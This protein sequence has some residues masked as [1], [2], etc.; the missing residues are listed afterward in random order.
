MWPDDESDTEELLASKRRTVE[1]AVEFAPE[2]A[3]HELAAVIGLDYDKIA[4]NREGNER[5]QENCV[6]DRKRGPHEASKSV[7]AEKTSRARTQEQTATQLRQQPRLKSKCL[8][9]CLQ[10]L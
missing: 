5:L 10:L 8:V 7:K 3:L 1:D 9:R 6:I 2:I 4:N